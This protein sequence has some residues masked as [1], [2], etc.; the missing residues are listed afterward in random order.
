[1]VCWDAWSDCNGWISKT[2]LRLIAVRTTLLVWWG[3]VLEKSRRQKEAKCVRAAC[4]G[5][6][7]YLKGESNHFKV[8]TNL[9]QAWFSTGKLQKTKKEPRRHIKNTRQQA[10]ALHTGRHEFIAWYVAFHANKS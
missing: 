10:E 1:M 4:I 7:K 8:N 9:R 6:L 2:S 5:N 3:E